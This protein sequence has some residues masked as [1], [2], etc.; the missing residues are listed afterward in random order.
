MSAAAGGAAAWDPVW[1]LRAPAQAS[2][3]G[4]SSYACWKRRVHAFLEAESVW[5]VVSESVTFDEMWPLPK[6]LEFIQKD[7]LGVH[8]LLMT[9][10]DSALRCIDQ[11]ECNRSW[12]IVKRIDTLFAE[13]RMKTVRR[14]RREFLALDFDA[15]N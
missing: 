7:K 10:H 9:L 5:E 4:A 12:L 1:N 8:L 15:F 13:H 14:V 11:R 6:Q 2:A 3:T